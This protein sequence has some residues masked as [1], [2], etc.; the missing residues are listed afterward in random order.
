MTMRALFWPP[1]DGRKTSRATT[2]M[3]VFFRTTFRTPPP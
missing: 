3:A 1:A 2:G